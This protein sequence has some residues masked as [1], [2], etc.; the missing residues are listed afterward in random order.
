MRTRERELLFALAA[1]LWAGAAAAF[2]SSEWLT[3]RDILTGEAARLRAAYS[4]C[5]A[6]ATSPADDLTIPVDT[7]EDGSVKTIIVARK[8]QYFHQ[9]GLVW[10]KDVVVKK[11]DRDGAPKGRID[12]RSCVV[13]R[14]TKSGWAEGMARIT[15]GKTSFTGSGIYFSSPEGYVM[16]TEGSDIVSRDLKFGG[17]LK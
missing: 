1:V 10:A 2:D 11:F 6:R 13:D 17:A 15:Q 5:L 16:V 7:Y 3:K 4:N 8:A 9:E 12:A 14:K